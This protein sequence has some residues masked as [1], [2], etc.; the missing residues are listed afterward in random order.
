M[1]QYCN[2]IL[3]LTTFTVSTLSKKDIFGT[4]IK[5]LSYRNVSLIETLIKGVK[6]VRDHL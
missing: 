1:F 2:F 3:S 6:R 5:S 4:G